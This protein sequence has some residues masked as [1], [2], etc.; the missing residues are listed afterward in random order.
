MMHRLIPCVL[1]VA[2]LLSQP[3]MISAQTDTS[4]YD[5]ETMNT[6]MTRTSVRAYTDEGV[7]DAQVER[8]L[9][10]AMAAPS[11]G[12]KQPW[13][14][15]VVRN[16]ETLRAISENLHTMTM[17]QDA[18]LAVVVCGDMDT[19][20]PGDGRDYWVEDASAATENLLLAAHAEGL[21]AV[22]CGIYPMQERVA[23]L[24]ELLSLPENIVP[25]NVV[26]IGHPAEQPTPKDKWRPDYVHLEAWDATAATAPEEPV[27]QWRQIEPWQLQDN[28]VSLFED[29]MAL[30]V[31]SGDSIN[32]MTIGW[33]GIGVLWQ[34]PVVTVYVEERRFTKHLMDDNDYFTV[35]AFP[36]EYAQVLHYLG[37]ASGRNEDKVAG[38]G[39]T[40]W[41]TDQ[42]TPAFDEGRLVIDCRKIYEAPFQ[43]A[44]FGDIPQQVYAAR[45][46]HTVYIGEIIGVYVKR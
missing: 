44:G 14:F 8:L 12:N 15:V 25:L 11:A 13:R 18:P 28:P 29:A 7:D 26:P 27:R 42:G 40:L 33:G 21:G 16:K 4:Q 10:A 41:Y 31:G 43:P 46:L 30:T 17:A 2:A 45:P 20:F 19:T 39:L 3:I 32:S 36:E 5:N 9:R 35:E 23:F 22:W 38:S 37:T 6:I 24:K 1:L 34:K